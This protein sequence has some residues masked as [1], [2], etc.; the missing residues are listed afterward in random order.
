MVSKEF[1]TNQNGYSTTFKCYI[2]GG[3]SIKFDVKAPIN[4]Y[5]MRVRPSLIAPEN[6]ILNGLVLFTKPKLFLMLVCY[7][8]TE[9]GIKR[10]KC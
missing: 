3:L 2:F 8:D 9:Y 10:K 6:P 4:L 1:I 7:F 5:G